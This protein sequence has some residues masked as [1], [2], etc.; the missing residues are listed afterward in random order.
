[1]SHDNFSQ[2]ELDKFDQFA[3][4][5]WDPHGSM[6]PLHILNPLRCQY[7]QDHSSITNQPVLDV[8][9]G[10]GLLAEALAKQHARVTAI[11]MSEGAL[12]VAR[13]HAEQHHITIDYQ[14]TT[15]ESFAAKNPAHFAVVTCMEMLEHV[16]DPSAI[17][18]A[19]ADLVKPGGTVFFSTI[20]RNW[21]AYLKA[22]VGAE[23]IL[24]LLPRGT[25]HYEKLI[26]PSEL[27]SWAQQA[28]L[29]LIDLRG[30]SYN[31]LNETCKLTT[32]VSVNY[33]CC[34]KKDTA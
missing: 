27:N 21:K 14:R 18:Q 19:C 26:R 23:Y 24:R 20:N 33:L 12:H 22:I 7:V 32:D 6:R 17:V 16:P 2:D 9:C 28:G 11:D 4:D 15:T 25:H 31:P 34:Y 3:K 5:W 1:M 10:A 8:G 30:V 13:Q 29:T